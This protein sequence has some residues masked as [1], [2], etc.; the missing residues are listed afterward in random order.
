MLAT[1]T[2][3]AVA[4]AASHTAEHGIPLNADVLWHWGPIPV[5]NSMLVL[6]IVTGMLI[7]F[8]WLAT[9][10][11]ALVPSGFQNF[12]EFLVESLYETL[13][14]ILGTHMTRRTFWF[15]ATIFITILTCNWLGLLPFF[16]NI[17]VVPLSGERV[18]LF[19]A[20]TADLNLPLAMATV[21]FFLWL[22][23]S[24]T[25]I[26]PWGMVKH[27][28]G[29]KGGLKADEFGF[30]IVVGKI[31]LFLVAVIFVF[32]GLIEL[33][34]IAFRQVSLPM[35]LFGNVFAGENLLHEM[36]KFFGGWLITIPFYG[37]EILVGFV[38]ALV[39][40]LL[41]AVFTN[42]MCAHDEAEGH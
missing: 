41:T 33:V 39:F 1:S 27:I 25:E 20:A 40:M 15:F 16:G 30:P 10:K 13:E 2:G 11:K 18:P 36:S 17:T 3:H 32:V 37:L 4:D 8:T 21:F 12:F 6:W 9:R 23:W 14:G 24:L 31:I 29:S 22:Y 34:S 26:G 28:F 7:T 35:R 38:Q 19:R 5:T 42:L